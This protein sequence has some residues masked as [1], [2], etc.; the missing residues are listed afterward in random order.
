MNRITQIILNEQHYIT[1]D[2]L[3]RRV[4]S[5]MTMDSSNWFKPVGVWE[6]LSIRLFSGSYN[7]VNREASDS[8]KLGTVRSKARRL[9]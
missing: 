7:Q 4:K 3:L 5:S 9:I 1:Q 2:V 8:I 6:F